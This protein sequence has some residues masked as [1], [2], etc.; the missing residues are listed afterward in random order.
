MK[1]QTQDTIQAA[2]PSPGYLLKLRAEE[3]AKR[4]EATQ[5]TTVPFW[6]KAWHFLAS[7]LLRFIQPAL[8]IDAAAQ[9]LAMHQYLLELHDTQMTELERAIQDIAERQQLALKQLDDDVAKNLERIEKKMGENSIH[10]GSM[11]KHIN[12]LVVFTDTLTRFMELH[13][14][15]LGRV[16]NRPIISV[17]G[18]TSISNRIATINH[19]I[20]RHKELA[21]ILDIHYADS[22]A[23]SKTI[24]LVEALASK[25]EMALLK[26][27][28]AV[29]AKV[30]AVFD[31]MEAVKL[32]MGWQLVP[33]GKAHIPESWESTLLNLMNDEFMALAEL[34]GFKSDD[35]E[36][37]PIYSCFTKDLTANNLAS[38]N[39]LSKQV[40]QLMADHNR[41]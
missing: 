4:Y 36:G 25:N 19:W 15:I 2:M 39:K 16:G 22:K 21:E 26:V 9:D 27:S 35:E 6:K 38:I 20:N 33:N 10:I 30:A 31:F 40:K 18:C 37:K 23:Y 24:D 29:D 14:D 8:R 5:D 34:L 32:K 28:D 3:C 1:D 11:A 7:L 41:D 17:T 13:G 12:W